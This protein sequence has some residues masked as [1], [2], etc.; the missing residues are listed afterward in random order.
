MAT[1]D[2]TLPYQD[3]VNLVPKN[4]RNPM[5][6]S[7]IDNLFNRFLTADESI[8]LYGYI[9]RKPASVDDH[10]P[11]V[12]QPTVERD[13]NAL[14]PVYS[15]KV[16]QETYSFTPQDLIR[17]AEVLGVSTDQ[18]SWLYSQANNYAPPIDLEKF[19]NFFNYYWT[20][21]ALPNLPTMAWNPTRA[22]EYYTVAAPLLTD[23]DKLNVRTASTG[24]DLPF[25]PT[26]SG[27]YPITFVVT[28]IDALHFTVQA[29]GTL[30]GFGPG[31]DL[32]GP[33]AL[34]SISPAPFPGPWP[35]DTYSVSF[36]VAS[37]P[38]PLITFDIVR[39]VVLDGLGI[40][41]GYESF[42]AG[43][44]FTITAPFISSTYNVVFSGSAGVKGKIKAVNSLDAY[45]KIGGVQ[46]KENDRV[47]IKDGADSDA[48]IY[49]VKAG[50][51]EIAPDFYSTTVVATA[52]ISGN[53]YT[54]LTI[55]STD[56]T[57]LGAASN[58][59]GLTF[60]AN[61]TPGTGT[62]TVVHNTTAGA[63]ARVWVQEGINAST[64]WVSQ[65]SLTTPGAWH[66]VQ[67]FSALT[68]NTS[69]WQEANYW[70]SSTDLA[71]MNI[72]RSKV[73][74]AVRPIIEYFAST[75]LNNYV[76]ADGLP[77]DGSDPTS[78]FYQQ[79]K[80]EFNQLPMFDLYR[81]DGHHARAVSPIFFYTEDPT[82]AI[83]PAL[84]RRVKHTTSA[85]ADFLFDH[86]LH[87]GASLLFY[88]SNL[89]LKTIWHP[90]YSAPAV[91]D[92]QY[93]G[94]G[95]GALSVDV[96]G[97]NPFTAQQIWTLTA[98]SG[99]TFKVVGSKNQVLPAPYDVLTVGVPYSN[100]LFNATI[101]A[102]LIPFDLG[103]AF[104]FRIGN[105]ETTRYVYRDQNDQLFDLY[106]GPTQDLNSIGAWQVPRMFFGNVAADN[107][108]E[109][110]EGTIYSHFR[111]ILANQLSLTPEDR[112][113]GGSIKLWSEQE[114]LLSSLLM[115]RDLTPIS[116]IDLSQR[117]YETALNSLV[118]LYLHE[119]IKYQ[120]TV[121]VLVT[122][123]DA[124]TPTDTTQLLDYL[125]R[126]RAAD[127]D[128]RNVLYDTTSPV[129]GFP[130]TLP[131]LGVS[132]LVSPGLYFDNEL[133]LTLM[134]HHDGHASPLFVNDQSFYDRMLSPHMTV[135][136]SDGTTTPAIGSYTTT[137]PAA[138]YKG[139]LWL[140][141]TATVSEYYVF[142]VLSDGA[143]APVAEAVGNHWYNRG[144]SSLYVWDGAA[145]QVEPSM[146]AA[147]VAFDPAALLNQLILDVELRLYN[148]IN[149]NH[150]AYFSAADV[151]SAL[152]SSLSTQLQR[153][154]A[155]WSATNGYDP[156]APDYVSTDPFTW[157]YSGLLTSQ[158]SPV[159][160]AAVPARWFN[161]LQSH[162]QTVA[163][164]V[165]TSRPNLEP[166]KLLGF[167]TKPAGWDATYA[168]SV[169]PSAVAA[170]GYITGVT[171]KAVSHST[172]PLTTLLAGLQTIDGVALQAG[173]TVLLTSEGGLANNG[174]WTV[175][176]SSWTRV[177]APL[178]QNLIVDVTEGSWYSG[179]SWWLSSTVTTVN[180]DPVLF[181]Q[182]RLWKEAMWA[183][184]SAAK[185]TLKLSVQIAND[186]LLPPY[187]NT[188]F[189]WASYALTN[190][191]PPTPAQA[192]LYGEGSL[193]ETIWTRS[194]EYRY[195][196]SRALFRADPLAWLGHLWGFEWVEVDGILY[197]GF[198]M[199]V[200]GYPRFRLQGDP[201]TPVSRTAP[202]GLTSVTGP[203][204]DIT[205]KHDG[206]TAAR[207]Q[208]WTISTSSGTVL[209]YLNEGAP[210]VTII[211]NGY[212]LTGLMIEDEGKAFR[213]GDSFHITGDGTGA[214]TVVLNQASYAQF[215]GYGQAFTNALRE[216]SI[217]ASQGYAAKAYRGWDVNL[218]YRAGGLV[219]TNDLRVFTDT[220]TL[221]S[222]AYEL[223]F[224]RS[225]YA[226]DIWV[227]GLRVSVVQIGSSTINKYGQTVATGDASDWT[228]RVDG[229]NTRYLG[230]E[231]N[232]FNPGDEVS[233]Y[234]LSKA[235]TPLP[236][237]QPTNVAAVQSTQLPLTVVGLQNV[238]DILFGY[239]QHLDT[240]GWRF[241]DDGIQNIDVETGRV[242]NWQLEIEKL[243]DRVYAGIALG[244]GHV[245]NPFIDRVWVEHDMGL[246]S[247]F[248]DTSLFDVT[249]HPGIFDTLGVKIE[250][251]ALT[252]LRGRNK[253]MITSAVPMFSA[254]AQ[255]DEYEHLFVFNDLSSPSTGEGLI[256][257]PFSAARIATI[258]L[259]GRR[260]A[261]HTL[262]PE[263]GGHYLVGDEVLQNIK[264]NVDNVAHYYD[265]DTVFEDEISTRH[266]LALLGFSPKQ[267]MADLDLTDRSQFNFWRGLIQMKGTNSSVDSFLNNDRFTDAKL[268][269]YWAYKIADY[270]DS[271]S[272]VFP[273][274]KLTVSDTV[275]QFTKLIF[276]ETALPVGYETFIPISAGDEARWFSIDDL[277]GETTFEAQV[278]GT[279]EKV[280]LL[281]EIVTLPF[282]ADKLVITGASATALND[283]TLKVTA[284][285]T[286]QVTG[287]GPSTPKFNPVK[288]FNYA[289]P[290][291]IEE[292]P[293]WHPAMGQHTPAALE[294]VNIIA[295]LD[296]ARYNIS[297]LVLGNVNYDPLRAW[298]AKEVGR[299]W[300]DT[301]N[302]DYL[303][304]ADQTI[305]TTVDERLSRWGTLADYATVDVVEWVE[306]SVPPANYNVQAAIDAGNADLD[307]YTRAAGE[308]Y[309]EKTYQRERTWF[310]RPI[311]WS[312]AGVPLEA[313][314]PALLGSTAGNLRFVGSLAVLNDGLFSD[315]G[316]DVGARF[317]A[318]QQ[319]DI[320]TR[321]LSE[322]VIVN[323][324]T[325]H[326]EG[327][328]F[329]ITATAYG[330]SAEI[331]I[332]V[333]K[334]TDKVG[335]L[336]FTG[337]MTST[338]LR[339]SAGITIDEWD[340][341][342][343]LHVT[344]VDNTAAVQMVQLRNDR[345]IDPGGLVTPLH[346][347]TF[348]AYA[349][350]VYSFDFT[351]FGLR[352]TVKLTATAVVPTTAL[353]DLLVAEL[354]SLITMYDAAPYEVVVSL[355]DPSSLITDSTEFSNYSND[356]QYIVNNGAGW[357]AWNVPT[358][359]QLTADSRVP[360]SVWLPYLGAFTQ[361]NPVTISTIQ[362]GAAGAETFTLNN[363]TVIEKYQT[364]WGDW[365]A[366]TG[367]SY[368]TTAVSAGNVSFVLDTGVTVDRVSVYVN[369]VAQLTGTYS[370]VGTALTVFAVTQGHIVTVI[371]RAYSPTSAELAFD[372]A[373][374]DNLLIQRQYKVD[375]QHVAIPIRDESG[376]ITSTKYYFW[377]K[378]RTT[379]ARDKKL[380]VKAVSTLLIDGPSQYL[381]FQH[382]NDVAPFFYDAITI[383][384]LSYV[385]TKDDTFKLRF[386]R[387]FT[388]RDDPQQLD[389]KDTHV[390]W[391]L[392]RPGQR[393][394][395]PELLW[396]KMTN[397]ACAKDAAGNTLPSPQRTA[398]DS[399]N[400][401]D[402]RFGFGVDQVLA[403]SDLVVS[404]L[405]FTILN[406]KLV[407]SSGA[408]SVP[409]YMT[410][411]D[412]NQSDTWF[413]SP[414]NTR[415]TL[416]RIWNE[417]KVL[418]INELFFAVLEDIIASNYQ[419]TDL[420]K[421]SRLSAYSIKVVNAAAA[422][423]TYE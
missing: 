309:G 258:K 98:T 88:K 56:F 86:G 201:I 69:D 99:T 312:Q 264:G 58:T 382:I 248:F 108:G 418:Q 419:L 336:Q 202:F 68:S 420:F 286:L 140:K 147:W 358:Q 174:L 192:Y 11:K 187:V 245:V 94:T 76:G 18:S 34:P 143:I 154:L 233:F 371:V 316:I 28:F 195:S 170:G 228:F 266:A 120:G 230:I 24:A 171:V 274:L 12:P 166:W 329:P 17:K 235:H 103:D 379:A 331:G 213:V 179:T 66:W 161:A 49:I 152:S 54:I 44:S 299:V 199:S 115:E 116:I 133:G 407:D 251:A 126:I 304:Y 346:N 64:M 271:R 403:P 85:S 205:I 164:V 30:V 406:T 351:E 7:L 123:P 14:V 141:P 42:N 250:T 80:T 72:D 226:K 107:S 234:A 5:I 177:A 178:V 272:K 267:Y 136:R 26:G 125:L 23:L 62:G 252:V 112:A 109:I 253:S 368:H 227:Q 275:Q 208:S 216:G 410:F 146:L 268:D 396:E 9:G 93:G 240:L 288:L 377:V 417:A 200:P 357:R 173:D 384:G 132:P 79:R 383:S 182:V 193:V 224:K 307:P 36:S 242:R 207:A 399:R 367:T 225:P 236:W 52:L 73:T 280:V 150:R 401:T 91:V 110:P 262:R 363:G 158:F 381:T 390:E 334:H 160:T 349:G 51:W 114:N 273:E 306:S 327:A 25:V 47:L 342:S 70:V 400:G 405:L 408:V 339:D 183:D 29:V 284:P 215:L 348:T 243:I 265:A 210:P 13:V 167:A 38:L 229:Y 81:Y 283:T 189:P 369:G 239:S 350:D 315:H 37:S 212:T 386:T 301:T 169:T 325:K 32:Q 172:A 176:S 40:P 27:F 57:L 55:D 221:P 289:Q 373:T 404:T 77:S 196:L 188:M 186:A 53:S 163:G 389:L 385:V 365:T 168:A 285:G 1:K 372:P 4:L 241:N 340:I 270:G 314:H 60:T 74:Q 101:T 39:D 423:P 269:E 344:E 217:D 206:Y 326:L 366:L 305:F 22:P 135:T 421:T 415:N 220:D 122:P 118:D 287:Y 43:D 257:D 127:N 59:V 8:P 361:L 50:A 71:A 378:N 198:D 203:A 185:P 374:A 333:L 6:T 165:P 21:A 345:G 319:D 321:P 370:L 197:D 308:V 41:L 300:W 279:Y 149:P 294:S 322:N 352:V 63:G 320:A 117:E 317:G 388:L 106:G 395:I 397:T 324:L 353:M 84:Q 78:I 332:V 2:Y 218:G 255:L 232:T 313:A 48:H 130:A 138:P 111:G 61:A 359:A 392:I 343:Y 89:A 20:A 376:T 364:S 354:N 222:S 139:E 128:V 362:S 355:I 290:E 330:L 102:G 209:G 87:D 144:T 151:Q 337:S 15:F 184:I 148:G 398:Y 137:P 409:D 402:T 113:F 67:D 175:S 249:G 65:A 411:L 190:T 310:A 82:A 157:N 153:E 180:V 328:T 105:F 254:H 414:E 394:R 100:G 380:S 16:G 181:E 391:T 223:R 83:D 134:R 302:L 219:S 297:T 338:Q 277:E 282:I 211:S 104:T 159:S 261:S 311:A 31:E 92:Q 263:F 246:L 90:G 387:N 191:Q 422:E 393:T 142:D 291:L 296:P 303:P 237:Y 131:Q 95:N 238:V 298:G 413:S 10:T 293:L 124:Q 145:W 97:V 356:P 259:N 45:Q 276:T 347:A 155:V 194:V 360:N 46:V 281:N 162:Q 292:I 75:Q 119:I 247:K 204:V 156:T 335:K 323:G 35:T 231:Y 278:V 412:F 214:F 256:Y 121:E 260:Q 341:A 375:Y 244:E 96:V 3:L 33:F 295:N 19:T 129:L 416:T 318:W